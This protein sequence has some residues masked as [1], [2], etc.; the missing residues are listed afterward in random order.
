MSATPT[1]KLRLAIALGAALLV[2]GGAGPAAASPK[3]KSPEDA[4]KQG[5]GAY[6]GGYYEIAHPALEA[7]AA[8]NLFLGQYYLARLYADNASSYTDHAKAYMLYQRLSDEHTDADPD[9]DSRAPFVAKALT[10]LAGYMRNGLPEIGLKPNAER[11][12][13]YLRHSAT[14]FNDEDAQFELAKIYLYGEP[15]EIDL[16][17]GRHWLSTVAQ[18][19]H[20]GGQAILALEQWRG[21]LVPRDPVRALTLI[22]IA[23]DNAPPSD[24]VW[25]EDIYQNIYCGSGSSTRKQVTGLVADWQDRYGRKPVIRDRSGLGVLSAEPVRTC[26]NGEAVSPLSGARLDASAGAAGKLPSAAIEP[27]QFLKG[28]S[29]TLVP[30]GGPPKSAPLDAPATGLRDVSTPAPPAGDPQE[31]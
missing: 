15:G 11:A 7:A 12:A 24:R 21:K 16:A 5:I 19:G 10:A 20:A 14:F 17:Q 3:F 8:A 27:Q 18:K 28:D 13:A 31:R 6:A 1:S 23:A 9:D 4:L 22:A 25:I 30:Q 26:E 2:A 29:S